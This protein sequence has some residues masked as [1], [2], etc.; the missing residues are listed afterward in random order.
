M[1]ADRGNPNP[2]APCREVV[3]LLPWLAGGTLEP[4]ERAQVE[5]HLASCAACREEAER[6]RDERQ[7]LRAQAAPS[8]S[9]HPT[10]L[11]R[12]FVRIERGDGLGEEGDGQTAPAAGPLAP[13]RQSWL[14]RTPAPA[15]WLLAAQ[16]AAL[17]GLGFWTLQERADAPPAFRTLG[18]ATAPAGDLRVVF[19]PTTSEAELRALLL[20]IRAILVAGPSAAGAYTL[21]LPADESRE[22]ALALLRADPR[23]RLAEIAA[24]RDAPR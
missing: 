12:L 5:Q 13:R 9:P 16:L 15:R 7:L 11:D 19:A 3:E 8:P 6:C 4:A 17:A 14:R 1:S 20:S 24:G 10:H 22:A 18:A 2:P 23:V 21:A